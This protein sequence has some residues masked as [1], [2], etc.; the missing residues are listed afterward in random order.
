MPPPPGPN[1]V[2]LMISPLNAI[3]LAYFS[4]QPA[5]GIQK[6]N[7]FKFLSDNYNYN[8]KVFSIF[9][10]SNIVH[11]DFPNVS[12]FLTL[13]FSESNACIGKSDNFHLPD[14]VQLFSNGRPDLYPFSRQQRERGQWNCILK[15]T[16]KFFSLLNSPVFYIY[17][18]YF[19]ILQY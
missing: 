19:I 9:P 10:P 8:S 15:A 4:L 14:E 1:R 13:T 7:N 2:N 5:E 18:L 11:G 12:Y 17:I 6:T 3:P 16:K